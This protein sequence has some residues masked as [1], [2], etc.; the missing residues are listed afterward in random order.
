[1]LLPRV[2]LWKHNNRVSIDNNESNYS[3]F[4][5]IKSDIC[6]INKK[7]FC[8]YYHSSDGVKFHHLF[9]C[10]LTVA[11]FLNKYRALTWDWSDFELQCELL[12]KDPHNNLLG[13]VDPF[14]SF[15][16]ARWAPHN[17]QL[18]GLKLHLP[19]GNY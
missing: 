14:F 1:M 12:Q 19:S 16:M 15:V 3:G 9:C 4:L 6:T 8:L 5:L 17:K 11:L 7:I 2:N 13:D 18:E 10:I